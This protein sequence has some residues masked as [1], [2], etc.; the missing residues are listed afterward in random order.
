MP[1]ASLKYSDATD[2][3]F[4]L[5]GMALSLFIFDAEQY[6]DSLR[7]EAPADMGVNLTPDFFTPA[8]PGLS[9]KSVWKD[10]FRH[11]QLSSAMAIGNLLARSL[12]RRHSELSHEVRSLMLSHLC[13]EG[14]DACGLESSEV[15][16]I[17]DNSFDYLS[18]IMRH[19]R[20]NSTICLMADELAS[21]KTL[22]R[23]DILRY[24]IPLGSL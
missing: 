19:P 20:I 5:C 15:I 3:A 13:R 23:D 6:I 8:N 11:F 22:S 7:I 21:R 12:A 18:S 4:G 17:F 10:T 9:V 2:R 16:Q 24:L 1:S 14:E